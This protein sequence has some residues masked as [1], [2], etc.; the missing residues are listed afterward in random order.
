MDGFDATQAPAAYRTVEP[1]VS[2]LTVSMTLGWL[3]NYAGMIHVSFKEKTYAMGIIPLCCN[4]A[5][6]FVYG[7]V[8][9]PKN[10][11]ELFATEMAV[12]V[13]IA[14]MYSA[15]KHS[16]NEWRHA[17]L[18]QRN[19]PYIFCA[20][21]LG[22]LTGHIAFAAYIGPAIAYT[23]SAAF[24]QLLLGA[25]GLCQLLC[26]GSSRGASFL[27]WISR[28]IGSLS[29][30][31][32]AGLR[33]RYWPE[34]FEWLNNPL[35]FWAAGMFLCLDLSYGLCYWYIKRVE[36]AEASKREQLAKCR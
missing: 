34:A 17:P 16:P 28:F 7:V 8:Y 36:T 18:I 24:C 5:W 30:M 35:I 14:V 4:I 1:F 33:L 9:P 3:V 6:E 22:F 23:W 20:C 25:G 29:V 15:I 32:L 21:T 31:G 27:L 10:R 11:L 26:R 13:N 12:I 19:L 2:I